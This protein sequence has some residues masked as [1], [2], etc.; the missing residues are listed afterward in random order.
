MQGRL[1]NAR[2][3]QEESIAHPDEEHNRLLCKRRQALTKSRNKT[4]PDDDED[5]A[6]QKIAAA[7]CITGISKANHLHFPAAGTTCNILPC[8]IVSKLEDQTILV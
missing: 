3:G 2:R 6:K 4:D 8:L 5:L 7:S 1:G